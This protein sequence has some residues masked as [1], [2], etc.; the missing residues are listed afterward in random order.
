MSVKVEQCF[1]LRRFPA[2]FA[3]L[4]ATLYALVCYI[5]NLQMQCLTR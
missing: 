5:F 1:V 3:V 2:L 4:V